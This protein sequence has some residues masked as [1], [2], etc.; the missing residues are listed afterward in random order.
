MSRNTPKQN[1]EGSKNPG[2]EDLIKARGEHSDDSVEGIL[3]LDEKEKGRKVEASTEEILKPEEKEKE[4]E[5]ETKE[6]IG[7]VAEAIRVSPSSISIIEENADKITE[8]LRADK[9]EDL[10]VFEAVA[11]LFV[12]LIEDG[13]GEGLFKEMRELLLGKTDEH[14]SNEEDI[15]TE[16]SRPQRPSGETESRPQRPSAHTEIRAG[17]LRQRIVGYA[18]SILGST[19]FQ[20]PEVRGG[21]LACAQVATD[22]LVKAGVLRK[23][24][25]GV[26]RTQ[27]ALLKAGWTKYGPNVPPNP[28]AGD[29]VIW[30][31]TQRRSNDGE[32]A[33]GHAHIGIVTGPNT[34]MSNSSNKK[35][36]REHKIGTSSSDGYWHKRGVDTFLRPPSSAT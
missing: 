35:M 12:K 34:A 5:E 26:S 22:V 20:G 21:R 19:N 24:I 4:K 9:G 1:P 7:T 18:K 10:G 36:P 23:R 8:V 33:L 6:L 2:F 32:V 27:T 17:S 28:E 11:L 15:E 25:N 16:S 3:N 29:V 13:R 30:N 14:D 31:R